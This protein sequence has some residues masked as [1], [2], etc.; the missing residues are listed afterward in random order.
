[1]A[2]SLLLSAR[3]GCCGV[4]GPVP[5]ATLDK[6][7]QSRA[8][9]ENVANYKGDVKMCICGC[10]DSTIWTRTVRRSNRRLAAPPQGAQRMMSSVIPMWAFLA[11]TVPLVLTPGAST[12][13]VLRNSLA[14]GTRAGLETAVGANAGSLCYGLLCAFGFALALR[15]MAGRL[16]RASRGRR[17]LSRLARLAVARS[18][19]QHPHTHSAR[20]TESA[21]AHSQH[22]VAERQRGLHHERSQP[23]DR[24]V[25]FPDP[26]AVHPG[27]RA[28]RLGGA[29]AHRCAHRARRELARRVGRGGR[30]ARAHARLGPASPD[31]RPRGR[32]RACWRSRSDCCYADVARRATLDRSWGMLRPCRGPIVQPCVSPSSCCCSRCW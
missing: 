15:A 16:E 27:R 24:H 25:L 5:S 8:D 32:H 21:G 7:P 17:R 2:R 30:D 18:C 31:P 3:P 4:V 28:D 6:C 10:M 20:R 9:Q 19:L 22:R 12:A 13:V 11:V 23:G 14:G 26:A 1:M 29:P